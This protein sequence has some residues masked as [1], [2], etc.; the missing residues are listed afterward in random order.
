MSFSRMVSQNSPAG[1]TWLM[2]RLLLSPVLKVPMGKVTGPI[3]PTNSSFPVKS[4]VSK[5]V[6]LLM[7]TEKGRD[8]DV[9]LELVNPDRAGD[10][11]PCFW[12]AVIVYVGGNHYFVALT[13]RSSC[14]H[15]T[16]GSIIAT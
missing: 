7:V 4:S 14:V 6:T 3:W 12:T 8:I 1:T 5:Q 11:F 13:V 2:S 9:S 15:S 10:H 16:S